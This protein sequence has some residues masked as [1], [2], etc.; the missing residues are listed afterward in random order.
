[1]A[2]GFFH[3]LVPEARLDGPRGA[4]L[5]PARPDNPG[6]HF[7]PFPSAL[8]EKCIGCGCPPEGTVLD[9]FVGSGT[10]MITG[11][12]LNRDVVGVEL[13]PEYCGFIVE[14]IEKATTQDFLFGKSTT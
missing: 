8:V 12:R 5:I 4:R 2:H 6:A 7:A 3:P 14:R 1:M 10:T 11:L 13:N 9:P